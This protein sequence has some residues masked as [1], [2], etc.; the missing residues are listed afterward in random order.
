MSQR[1]AETPEE[2]LRRAKEEA[3]QR[4]LRRIAMAVERSNE[5]GQSAVHLTGLIE[6]T[7]AMN[8]LEESAGRVVQAMALIVVA[9][10]DVA[11]ILQQ[12]AEEEND[13]G[14]ADG[15]ARLDR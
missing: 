1:S 10:E 12:P 2:A 6:I 11:K 5:Q 14:P 4:E 8:K 3:I 15:D 13:A 7:A 9:L